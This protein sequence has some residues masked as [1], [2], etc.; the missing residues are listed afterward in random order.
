MDLNS[1]VDIAD[2]HHWVKEQSVSHPDAGVRHNLAVI[3]EQL[4]QIVNRL[5]GEPVIHPVRS[6]EPIVDGL[7]ERVAALERDSEFRYA[8]IAKAAS[9]IPNDEP[10]GWWDRIKSSITG[11]TG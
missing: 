1:P 5:G 10:K 8:M 9:P 2:L 7:L 4:G 6:L 3:D 11:K